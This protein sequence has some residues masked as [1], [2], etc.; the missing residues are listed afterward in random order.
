MVQGVFYRAS[1]V[2][3]ARQLQLSGYVK[4]LVDGRVEVLAEGNESLLG[5]LIHWC[6]IGPP[7]AGVEDVSV[8]WI[9]PT[10]QYAGFRPK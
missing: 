1:T 9:K 4:N 3:K 2:Q 5:Q 7:A 10:G 8:E 6:R